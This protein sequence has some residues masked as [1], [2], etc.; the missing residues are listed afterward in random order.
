MNLS[1]RTARSKRSFLKR[2]GSSVVAVS[3]LAGCA[4]PASPAAESIQTEL[5]AVQEEQQRLDKAIERQ[6]LILRD[7]EILRDNAPLAAEET[8]YQRYLAE[9]YSRRSARLTVLREQN[10]ELRAIEYRLERFRD[11]GSSIEPASVWAAGDDEPHE[12]PADLRPVYNLEISPLL[13][14]RPIAVQP[15]VSTKLSFSI[16]PHDAE[17]SVLTEDSTTSPAILTLTRGEPLDLNVTLDCRVCTYEPY[18]RAVIR[19]LPDTGASAAAAE[20]DIVPDPSLADPDT[21]SG[22]LIL[23]VDVRGIDLDVIHVPV[24]LGAPTAQQIAEWKAPRPRHLQDADLSAGDVPDLIIDITDAPNFMQVTLIP[25]LEDL[26]TTLSDAI[27]REPAQFWTFDAGASKDD[28]DDTVRNV[29]LELKALIEQE[30]GPIQDVYAKFGTDLTLD[31]SAARLDIQMPDK[32][33][34][35]KILRKHGWRLYSSV[36]LGGERDLRNA[37]RAL[38]RFGPVPDQDGQE[39]RPLRVKIRATSVYA[40]WQL[41]YTRGTFLASDVDPDLF[42]GFRYELGTRQFV[43]T[44]Q[45]SLASAMA[46]PTAE[47]TVFAAYRGAGGSDEVADRARLLYEHVDNE[48]DGDLVVAYSKSEFLNRLQTEGSAVQMIV[49]Y[50]H[51]S[52]GTEVVPTAADGGLAVVDQLAGQRFMFSS[53]DFLAPMEISDVTPAPDEGV[54]LSGQ[55]FVIFNAC[56]TGAGGN[57]AMN[58]NGFVGVLTKAGARVVIVTETPVWNNFAHHFGTHIVDSLLSG[59]SAQ[60]ALHKVRRDHLDRWHNPLG[61]VYTL[62]GNPSARIVADP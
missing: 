48:L 35:L 53:D 59:N 57:R 4:K 62:Y 56:E 25:I 18:Q 38:E 46:K 45:T 19:Y 24:V 37:M 22:E 14:R 33:G 41:M 15:H 36:F 27:A 23:T 61:L 26:H 58:N 47:Q 50:G 42:W 1:L 17:G 40:P 54:L 30:K 7:I 8:R 21:Q 20:F 51:A 49:A 12:S 28:L 52:S 16:G 13:S 5:L 43:N 2:A 60:R 44:A 11:D 29:Y 10:E 9:E 3:L 34:M 31:P 6:E 39:P 32:Q 55:P